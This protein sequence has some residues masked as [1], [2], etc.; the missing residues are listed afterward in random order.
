MFNF[1]TVQSLFFH[2][3]SIQHMTG[4]GLYVHNCDNVTVT[5]CSYY[6]SAVCDSDSP[7]FFSDGGA[8]GIA[9]NTQ[10]SNTSYTLELSHSN[11]TKCCSSNNDFQTGYGGGVYLQTLGVGSVTVVLS[12][13]ILSQNS[14]EII[15][16]NL[17]V[18]LYGHGRVTLTISNCLITKSGGGGEMYFEVGNGQSSITIQNTDLVENVI[19]DHGPS[20]LSYRSPNSARGSLSLINSTIVHTETHSDYGVRITGCCP[21][22]IITNTRISIKQNDYGFILKELK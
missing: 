9:Y 21:I 17:A 11:M 2:K 22:V 4:R 20:E 6:H 10:Y 18:I 12:H 3:N 13:L 5:N 8:V 7:L 19:N 15:G 16:G 1:Q 14:A